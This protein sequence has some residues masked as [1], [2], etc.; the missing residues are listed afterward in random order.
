ML[1]HYQARA[2]HPPAPAAPVAAPKP[3]GKRAMDSFLNEIK[4]YV[5]S[6]ERTSKADWA[7]IRKHENPAWVRSQKVSPL[8]SMRFVPL[9]AARTSCSLSSGR[10]IGDRSCRS[11]QYRRAH[12]QA[13]ELNI[14]VAWESNPAGKPAAA[15]QIE[16]SSQVCIES[17]DEN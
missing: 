4:R 17:K 14:D 8:C 11:V 16:V 10:V 6:S 5:W 1:Q 13:V 12:H 15:P 2:A 3:K 9:S 7:V